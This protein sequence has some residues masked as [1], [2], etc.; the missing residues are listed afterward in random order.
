[1]QLMFTYLPLL[2]FFYLP[3]PVIPHTRMTEIVSQI[4]K[5]KL[6]H[7]AKELVLELSRNDEDGEDAEVPYVWY[8]IR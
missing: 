3:D 8:S 7:H 4:S 5:Q 1:M 2:L 6:G